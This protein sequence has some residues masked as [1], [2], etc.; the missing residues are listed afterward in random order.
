[1]KRIQIVINEHFLFCIFSRTL[2]LGW[3]GMGS[4]NV[5]CAINFIRKQISFS[6]AVDFTNRTSVHMHFYQIANWIS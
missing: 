5:K 3:D 4:T 6:V 1:M 2:S